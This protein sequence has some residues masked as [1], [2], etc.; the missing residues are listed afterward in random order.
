[1]GHHIILAYQAAIKKAM[2]SIAFFMAACA[3][4]MKID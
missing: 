1:L 2:Q 3:A 4:Q